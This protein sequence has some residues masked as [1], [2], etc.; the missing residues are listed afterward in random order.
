VFLLGTGVLVGCGSSEVAPVTYTADQ[1]EAIA[2]ATRAV[3]Q[4]ED[5]ASRAEYQIQK[6]RDGWQVTAWRVEHPEAKGNARYVP[7]GFRTIL[8]DR[9]GQ[10][11]E[12]KNSK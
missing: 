10:V 4:N 7:W 1:Q 2:A 8:V 12:Y 11:A 9:R 5:W 6:H 3:R